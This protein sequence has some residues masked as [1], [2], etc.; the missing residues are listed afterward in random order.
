MITYRVVLS[1]EDDEYTARRAL[2][3]VQALYPKMPVTLERVVTFDAV[4]K[5][6][7]EV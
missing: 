1:Y 4:D 3:A 5:V 7:N 6:D 2:R